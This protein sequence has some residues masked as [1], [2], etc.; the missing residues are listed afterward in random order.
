MLEDWR[1]RHGACARVC[2]A[3]FVTGT[4]C[5]WQ[6]LRWACPE[7]GGVV[8][9]EDIWRG[10]AGVTF[11]SPLDISLRKRSRLSLMTFWFSNFGTF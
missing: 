9:E 5:G 1:C 11:V 7:T 2:M 4:F 3:W 8:F 10:S 6:F